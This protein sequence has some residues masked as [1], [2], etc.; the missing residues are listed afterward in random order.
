M[1]TVINVTDLMKTTSSNVD[2]VAFDGASDT[3]FVTFKNGSLYK[4]EGVSE[5]EFIALKEAKSVGSYLSR[6]FLKKGFGYEKLEDTELS[7]PTLA[8]KE[9]EGVEEGQDD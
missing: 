1:K 7:L 4:Y 3:A 2:S 6:I 5:E 8:K 9:T